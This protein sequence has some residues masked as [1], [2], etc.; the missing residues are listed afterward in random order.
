LYQ[1]KLFVSRKANGWPTRVLG[2][3][4]LSPSLSVKLK[5]GHGEATMAIL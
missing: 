3:C 2:T 4:K 5:W 1:C